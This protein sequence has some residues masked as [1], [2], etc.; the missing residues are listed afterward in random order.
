[1]GVLV[2]WTA[3][4]DGAVWW[5]ALAAAIFGWIVL[6][7]LLDC[8]ESR[9]AVASLVASALLFATG[10][11]A[12]LGIVASLQGPVEPMVVA[13]S[14]MLGSLALVF[15]LVAY[16]RYVVLDAEGH[17]QHAEPKVK[18]KPATAPPTIKLPTS[19]S[20]STMPS[21]SAAAGS[22]MKQNAGQGGLLSSV[23][24]ASL[25]LAQQS[26]DDDRWVDGSRPIKDDD[27]DDEPSRSDQ[28]LSKAE[29]KQLRKLKAQNRAA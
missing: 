14:K 27:C 28:K 22:T 16:I 9:L 8:R 29:R 21:K 17:I 4:R 3:L 24:A 23:R 18:R 25:K 13:G 5:M 12:H 19:S 26:S 1:M 6:R 7:V 10:L 20:G 2:G 15:A 11:V